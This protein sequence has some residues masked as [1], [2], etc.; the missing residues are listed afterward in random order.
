MI[1]ENPQERLSMQNFLTQNV[2]YLYGVYLGDG[3]C[4]K[5]QRQYTFNII[6]EDKDVIKRTQIIVNQLLNKNYLITKIKPNNKE[7]Y[8]Y[9]AWN[10]ELFNSLITCTN[11]KSKIPEIIINSSREIKKEFISGLM[12]TDG[13]VSVGINKL[14]QQRFSLG[15]V[16][17]AKWLDNFIFLLK[18]MGV[19]IGKKT[20]KKKYRS[21]NEKDCY[22]ININLRSFVENGLYF[23]CQRKQ[24]ILQKYKEEVKYQKY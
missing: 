23:R 1:A 4:N 24:D 14:G 13:Y 16:N 22:Q 6:S 8:R 9:R 7:L 12:D 10:K 21:K 11:N 2:A 5:T 20:L 3:F 17:S 15:F 19:K 18:S